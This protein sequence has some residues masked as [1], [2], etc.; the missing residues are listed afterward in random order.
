MPRRIPGYRVDVWCAPLGWRYEV[1]N[2]TN[3]RLVADG[4]EGSRYHARKEGEEEALRLAAHHRRYKMAKKLKSININIATKNS[5]FANEPGLE[6]T[7]ILLK[8]VHK[9]E[10]A[11]DLVF[12]KVA[13]MDSNGNTVGHLEGE[14][15]EES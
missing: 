1:R 5:A 4:Y 15:E 6:V 8:L 12:D 13:L 10:M 2:D 9:L 14:F 7:Q 11:P 3:N